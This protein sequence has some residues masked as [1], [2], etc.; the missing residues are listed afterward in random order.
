MRSNDKLNVPAQLRNL[1]APHRQEMSHE[2][3]PN[4]HRVSQQGLAP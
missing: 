2:G 4:R 1:R 3:R